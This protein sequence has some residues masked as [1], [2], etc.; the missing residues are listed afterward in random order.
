MEYDDASD[1]FAF[2]G[3]GFHE[4]E[5]DGSDISWYLGTVQNEYDL[6][7]IKE[8]MDGRKGKQIRHDQ[9]SS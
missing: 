5:S 9:P 6:E 8:Q 7:A 1:T 3:S 4:L 2:M